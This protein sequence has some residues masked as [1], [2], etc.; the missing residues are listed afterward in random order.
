MPKR[1]QR[2]NVEIR[3]LQ[4][5]DL[6]RVMALEE[7]CQ[8]HPWTR[9]NM[10][11]ELCRIAPEAFSFVAETSHGQAMSYVIGRAI[12]GELWVLQVGT[13]PDY[14]RQRCSF[15]LLQEV[16]KK[17]A[18]MGMERALLEVRANNEGAIALYQTLSFEQDGYRSEYYPPLRAG[19]PKEDAILMSHL[20]R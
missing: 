18:E 9:E 6:D 7:A 11:E 10:V 12:A 1:Y 8:P 17:A 20:F 16:L 13:H 5:S 15:R 4:P 19:D 2:L 14:R 3:K